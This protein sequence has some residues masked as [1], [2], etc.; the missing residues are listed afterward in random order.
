[1]RNF[2]QQISEPWMSVAK[3]T[4]IAASSAFLKHSLIHGT[5][6]VIHFFG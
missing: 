5:R 6:S 2:R 3:K 4:F 1:L